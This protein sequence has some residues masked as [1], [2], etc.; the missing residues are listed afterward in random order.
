MYPFSFSRAKQR[1][2]KPRWAGVYCTIEKFSACVFMI[3]MPLYFPICTYEICPRSVLW[4]VYRNLRKGVFCVS[5]PCSGVLTG[6]SPSSAP[7]YTNHLV[8]ITSVSTQPIFCHPE[9]GGITFLRYIVE[10]P[11]SH[12]VRKPRRTSDEHPPL[13]AE[14]VFI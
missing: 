13:K 9:L 10:N 4:P 8:L 12:R 11:Q 7:T 1:W 6:N 5:T 14:N 3:N 2:A